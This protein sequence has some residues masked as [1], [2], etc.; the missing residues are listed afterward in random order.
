MCMYV[1]V[2]IYLYNPFI[3]WGYSMAFFHPEVEPASPALASPPMRRS[4][5][6]L[7]GT[8]SGRNLRLAAITAGFWPWK[9]RMGHGYGFLKYHLDYMR[10]YGIVWILWDIWGILKSW[11]YPQSSI[12]HPFRTMGFSM[13]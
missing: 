6:S 12:F 3:H 11:G 7:S 1:C 13:K 8:S 2:C 4:I 5:H 10:F 9:T